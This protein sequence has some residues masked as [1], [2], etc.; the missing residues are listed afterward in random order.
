MDIGEK[1][2]TMII[3]GI[4]SYSDDIRNWMSVPVKEI[5][6]E[7]EDTETFPDF[8]CELIQYELDS[9]NTGVIITDNKTGETILEVRH[10]PDGGYSGGRLSR[11][12]LSK[13]DIGYTWYRYCKKHPDV[14]DKL[15][16]KIKND[17]A[18]KWLRKR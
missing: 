16:G 1:N 14:F 6:I 12:N 3:N 10:S 8:V 11:V 15:D 9:G 18:G 17:T 13:D 5:K 4:F 2:R 7:W